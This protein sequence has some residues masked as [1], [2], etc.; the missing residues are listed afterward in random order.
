MISVYIYIRYVDTKSL[1]KILSYNLGGG[2]RGRGWGEG[3][4]QPGAI[5]LWQ[6]TKKS[7]QYQFV[8]DCHN[9]AGFTEKAAIEG[10]SFH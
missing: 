3:A 1:L 10:Y 8:T 7:L 9:G 5:H 6:I 4:L 2:G